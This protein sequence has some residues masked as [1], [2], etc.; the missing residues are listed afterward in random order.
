V[1]LVDDELQRAPAV[2]TE[3]LEAC[4]LWLDRDARGPRGV[5]GSCAV[6]RDRDGGALGR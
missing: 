4:E 3:A 6:R 1:R 2:G 5:D